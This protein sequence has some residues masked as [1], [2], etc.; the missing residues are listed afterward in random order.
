[1]GR[2][3][4]NPFS[5]EIY[6]YV[7]TKLARIGV[8]LAA[9]VLAGTTFALAETSATPA[10]TN[11]AQAA[12][13]PTATPNPFAY[14]GYIRAYD[15]TRQNAYSG[16]AANNQQSFNAAISLHAEYN[17]TVGVPGLGLGASYL[18]ANPLS[19]CT[20]AVSHLTPPCGGWTPTT[21]PGKL[22]PDDTLPGFELNTL[23]ETYL[24]YKASNFFIKGGDLVSPGTQV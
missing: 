5:K 14:R 13:A 15:F 23:Y 10:P 3:L 6:F 12:P 20:S 21:G 16:H 11:V 8:S 4:L 18:Y 2:Y 19:N 7:F 22:N 24:Q 9:I 17:Y 1:M